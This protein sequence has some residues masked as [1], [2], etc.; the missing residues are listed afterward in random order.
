MSEKQQ[1]QATSKNRKILMAVAMVIVLGV[2]PAISW[3]YLKNGLDWR[4]DALAELGSFGQIRGAYI[5]YPDGTKENQLAESVCVIH[6]FGAEPDLTPENKQI[7][8]TNKRLYDQFGKMSDGT[9]RPFFK[10]VM[11][12]E[13]GT[14][15]F[16]SEI[17]KIPSIDYATWVQ[18]GGLGSWGTILNNGY[19]K[20]R[21]D[22]KAKEH[23]Y[24]YALAD[25]T[26]QIRCFY[27]ALD[28]KQVERMVQQIAL[29]LSIKK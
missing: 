3:L 22:K 14:T 25:A 12:F 6:N 2:L 7:I 20:F 27:N 26:G 18:T 21:I 9:P 4:K 11:I 17:Q 24:V 23:K 13:G 16:R 10:I 28:E 5:I 8:D 29:M 1:P 15:E 19:E